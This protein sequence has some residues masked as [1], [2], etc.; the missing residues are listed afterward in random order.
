MAISQAGGN[1]SDLPVIPLSRDARCPLHP[2]AE[3]DV[4]R[5]SE[6][7]KRVIWHGQEFWMISRHSDIREALTDPRVSADFSTF[8]GEYLEETT[9]F[10]WSSRAW[11]T[12]STIGYAA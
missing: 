4:W 3:F 1:A 8:E 11:T 10:P 6:G 7:L 5:K 2:P 12:P 9:M